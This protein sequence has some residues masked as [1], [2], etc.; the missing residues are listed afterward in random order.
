MSARRDEHLTVRLTPEEMRCVERW[1]LG[2]P[3]QRG[4]GAVI[5]MLIREELERERARERARRTVAAD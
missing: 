2:D 4:K 1:A 5:R 3:E